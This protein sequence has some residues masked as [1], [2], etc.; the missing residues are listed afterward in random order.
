MGE[1]IPSVSRNFRDTSKGLPAPALLTSSDTAM[2]CG[3]GSRKKMISA[4]IRA[5]RT[6]TS[7]FGTGGLSIESERSWQKGGAQRWCQRASL[8][9]P[10][11][12]RKHPYRNKVKITN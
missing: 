3:R 9:L 1:D 12:Y 7:A 8:R 11:A 2:W 10:G 5:S 4:A 6:P